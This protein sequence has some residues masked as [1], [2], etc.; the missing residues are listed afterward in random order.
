MQSSTC[1][2]VS[3]V[4]MEEQVFRVFR[5][6]LNTAPLTVDPAPDDESAP[7][8]EPPTSPADGPP[9]TYERLAVQGPFTALEQLDNASGILRVWYLLLEGLAGATATCPR[10]HQPQTME[11]LFTLLRSLANRP[12]AEFGIYCVNHLLLPMVQGWLR[13]TGRRHRGWDAFATNFKQCCGLAT[14]LVVFYH[15]TLPADASERQRAGAQLM[16]RQ[17]LLVMI[18]C[19]C[20]PHEVISRL[21]CACIRHL[22]M[23]GGAEGLRPE[24]WEL[25][26]VALHRALALTLRPLHRLMAAF[27]ADSDNFY[28]DIGQVKV[29]ARRDCTGRE[30]DRL[31]QLAH[32]VFLLD[33]QRPLALETSEHPEAE[34]R[35]Y[36]F[37]L[38]APGGGEESLVRVPFRHLV[39]GL[40]AHQI[41]LQTV[42]ALLLQGT[43][44][45]VPSLVNVLVASGPP[46]AAGASD[47]LP[48]FLS[49]LSERHVHTLLDGL[50]GSQRAALHFD[51]RP[52]LKFLV[53]KVSGA[54]RA[55]N[56]YKQAGASWTL[57]AVSLLDVVTERQV[58]DLI[59]EYKRRKPARAMPTDSEAHRKVWTDMLVSTLGLVAQQEDATFRLLLPVVHPSRIG[60]VYGFASE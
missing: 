15:K 26:T 6:Q 25:V 11:T 24:Q 46:A 43:R 23:S 5:I 18:E 20:Q 13:R 29:A 39:V 53:Q 41:L 40:L 51:A 27:H 57:R 47:A 10:R 7:P 42:G 49:Q 31:R 12:G 37:L 28:G 14:D 35:S 56:L 60:A 1:C 16:M 32:Q 54:E 52:G 34:D 21:G 38:Y 50:A 33:D 30:S 58:G 59:S 17:L 3:E 44:H 55:A 36:V 9:V 48:G 45:V 19:V 4:Q 8:E 2:K 22:V